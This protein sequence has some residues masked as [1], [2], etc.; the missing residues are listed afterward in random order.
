[1]EITFDV[2]S[3]F[4]RI[5]WTRNALGYINRE[6]EAC[7]VAS[8]NKKISFSYGE[9]CSDE[10]RKKQYSGIIICPPIFFRIEGEK[11]C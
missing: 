9:L 4:A 2:E 7:E 3:N 1:M 5:C 11:I 6:G 10:A 8:E